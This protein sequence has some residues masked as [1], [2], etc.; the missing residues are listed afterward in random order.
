MKSRFKLKVLVSVNI[1]LI[2]L[3]AV[4]FLWK[5]GSASTPVQQNEFALSDTGRVDKIVIDDLVL[6]KS[7]D[8]S[9]KNTDG[10]LVDQLRIE[11][12]LELLTQI[13]VKRDVP[14]D[15][16]RTAAERLFAE[17][18][19]VQLSA[20]GAGV[21]SYRVLGV[22]E[23]EAWA[24]YEGSRPRVVYVPGMF[25]DF[26]NIFVS[27]AVAW[28]DRRLLPTSWKTLDA[29]TLSAQGPNQDGIK[30]HLSFDGS[31]YQVKGV[32]QLDSALVYQ[33]VSAIGQ[34]RGKSFIERT[35]L[36]DS[37][38]QTKPLCTFTIKD[39]S[40]KEPDAVSIYILQNKLYGYK[41]LTGDVLSLNPQSVKQ[42]L[43]P[44]KFFERK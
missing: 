44:A 42:Y 30:L 26:D 40:R 19:H 20:G 22:N 41:Q 16:Y 29:L 6:S 38:L 15:A 9:W 5:G 37:L 14:D 31:F 24:M 7:P 1:L 25:V 36:K 34:W 21:L 4:T 10:V 28:K 18:K 2:G 43:V 3:I 13:Q 12:F 17:G 27:D 23:T 35:S 8:G 39:I 32:S 33:Y 11:K